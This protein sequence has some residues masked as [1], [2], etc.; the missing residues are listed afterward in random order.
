MLRRSWSDEQRRTCRAYADRYLL[1]L[2]GVDHRLYPA[3]DD[4]VASFCTNRRRP[5]SYHP[6]LA[7]GG[8]AIIAVVTTHIELG[9][10]SQRATCTSGNH[11]LLHL[12]AMLQYSSVTCEV[13]CRPVLFRQLR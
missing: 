6:L 5:L 3:A 13:L 2:Q 11:P 9:F 12:L 7:G 10:P 1:M 4:T 8:C